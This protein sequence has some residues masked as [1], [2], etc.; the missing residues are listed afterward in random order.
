MLEAV[1]THDDLRLRNVTYACLVRL[2]RVPEAAEVAAESGRS[3][4]AVI[5]GW[6]RLHSEHAL[7][8]SPT[9]E[10]VMANPFSGVPTAYR[11]Q[12]AGHWWYGNCA[13]D[14]FGIC[15]ALHTDGQIETRCP[16]C[17]QRLSIAV[18]NGRPDQ[19]LL[20]HCLVPAARWW[21]DIV[22]T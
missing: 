6:K 7:V 10:I 9:G 20:F 4:A 17:G 21:D 5:A 13:W 12:A 15:G 8:L 14:A 1:L 3:R 18:R 16:D 19:D 11:V 22:F 2:G